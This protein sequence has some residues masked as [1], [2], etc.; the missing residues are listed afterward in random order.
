M[1]DLTAAGGTEHRTK[2][3]L[4]S[5]TIKPNGGEKWMSDRDTDGNIMNATASEAP[6][7][8]IDSGIRAAAAS[9][10]RM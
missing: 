8:K 4:G 7:P 1:A 10:R 5:V 2:F 6:V 9:G 3:H